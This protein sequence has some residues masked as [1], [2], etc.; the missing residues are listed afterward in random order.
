V[1]VGFPASACVYVTEHV[2]VFVVAPASVHTP[3]EPNVPF[4][5]D[6][7]VTVPAGWA[8]V[9]V[10]S[11]SVTVA[12]HV[13]G[14][15]GVSAG[16]ETAVNVPWTTAMFW[17]KASV[18]PVKAVPVVPPLFFTSAKVVPLVSV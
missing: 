12:V 8:A 13:V 6:V 7:S 1:S 9:P 11:L 3:P 15:P 14:L 4:P 16:Q 10:I 2:E 18:R 5:L 17:A